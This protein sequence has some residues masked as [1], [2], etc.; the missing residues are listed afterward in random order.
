[1]RYNTGKPPVVRMINIH[2]SPLNGLLVEMSKTAFN[3]YDTKLKS[4]PGGYS[5]R[6]IHLGLAIPVTIDRSGMARGIARYIGACLDNPSKISLERGA[7]TFARVL[8]AVTQKYAHSS[9][10]IDAADYPVLLDAAY[11]AAIEL[12]AKKASGT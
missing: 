7:S 6:V 8:Y 4:A 2:E 10:Y 11:D 3:D 9:E 12:L 5:L 1:M